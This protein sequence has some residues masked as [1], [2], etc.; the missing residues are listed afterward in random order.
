MRIVWEVVSVLESEALILLTL[1][2]TFCPRVTRGQNVMINIVRM[3][4]PN[5]FQPM[6]AAAWD[7]PA[8]RSDRDRDHFAK[9]DFSPGLTKVI[10]TGGRL[11][12]GRGGVLFA[13]SIELGS[14]IAGLGSGRMG[15]AGMVPEAAALA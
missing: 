2:M 8:V 13:G 3:F 9:G 6:A 7:E 15:G 12:L 11:L 1:I 5:L 14:S 10:F 4:A